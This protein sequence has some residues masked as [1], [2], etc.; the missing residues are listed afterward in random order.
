MEEALAACKQDA[1][2]R[3]RCNISLQSLVSE[4]TDTLRFSAHSDPVKAS[5]SIG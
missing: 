3:P 5:H 2:T 1:M 4:R